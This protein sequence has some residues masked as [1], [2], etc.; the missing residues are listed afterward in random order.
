MEEKLTKDIN[1]LKERMNTIK[2]TLD[3]AKV[4]EERNLP[5]KNGGSIEDKVSKLEEEADKKLFNAKALEEL[6]DLSSDK[7]EEEELKRLF[8]ELEKEY[9]GG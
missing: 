8:D 3:S 6:N 2:N 4:I 7:A 5:G 9:G 1:T